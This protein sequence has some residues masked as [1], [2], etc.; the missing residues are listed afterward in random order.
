MKRDVI[1]I[2]CV[3]ILILTLI[4]G[5]DVRGI[6]EISIIENRPLV[7]FP[8]FS[9]DS[10]FDTSYQSN[11]EDALTDQILFGENFKATFNSIKNNNLNIMVYV[12]KGLEGSKANKLGSNNIDK[13]ELNIEDLE[14]LLTEELL[15]NDGKIPNNIS[16]ETSLTPKGSNFFAIDDSGHIVAIKRS[17]SDSNELFEAKA[18]NFNEL[19]KNYPELSYFIYYI[20]TSADIDFINGEI[21]HD[22]VNSLFAKL[23]S[24]IKRGALY[25]NNLNTFKKYFYK[26]DHHWNTEGQLKGYRDIIELLKGE[27]ELKLDIKTELI[28]D[29]KYYGYRARSISDFSVSDEFSVLVADLPEYEVFINGKEKPYDNKK[30]YIAGEHSWDKG[31]NHYGTANGGDYALVEYRFNQPENENILVF[32]ESFSNPINSFIASYY[33][34]T[35]FIDLR[36][37]EKTYGRKFDFGDFVND[38]NIDQ[39]LFSGYYFFYANNEFLITD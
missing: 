10:F 23:D 20:E 1:F 5:I 37:Y 14:K 19:V 12:L 30:E 27:D 38:H 39:V 4:I 13:V 9:M 36:F 6:N 32:V 15:I 18:A 31:F 33:N 11:I 17:V 3:S 24:S 29:I 34:N 22:L 7:D 26:T 28:K 2:V 21:N 35:Y 16:F 8:R 25:I